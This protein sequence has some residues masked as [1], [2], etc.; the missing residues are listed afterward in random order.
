MRVRRETRGKAEGDPDDAL[1]GFVPPSLVC[2]G[3]ALAVLKRVNVLAESNALALDIG[4][5]LAKI[6][7]FQPNTRGT[8]ERQRQLRNAVPPNRKTLRRFAMY[9]P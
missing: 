6:L 9:C 5:S 2:K 1:D 8:A 7:Y 4:G 3:T